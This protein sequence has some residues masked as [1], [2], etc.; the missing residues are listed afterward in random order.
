[1]FACIQLSLNGSSLAEIHLS[2]SQSLI[3]LFIQKAD[4]YTAFLITYRNAAFFPSPVI[5]RMNMAKQYH[6]HQWPVGQAKE[7]D[8]FCHSSRSHLTALIVVFK[9]PRGLQMK[10]SGSRTQKIWQPILHINKLQSG[11]RTVTK[12]VKVLKIKPMWNSWR[13]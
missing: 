8:S 2:A 10:D 3:L 1:M 4:A 13:F 7:N 12:M 5:S 9:R 6:K 11:K